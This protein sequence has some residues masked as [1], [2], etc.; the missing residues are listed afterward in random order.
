M[1]KRLHLMSTLQVRPAPNGRNRAW[2]L[3]DHL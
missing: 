3:L 2:D 1:S